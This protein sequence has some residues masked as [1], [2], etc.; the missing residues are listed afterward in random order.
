MKDIELV[1]DA[2]KLIEKEDLSEHEKNRIVVRFLLNK[3]FNES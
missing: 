1:F 2:L 3:F